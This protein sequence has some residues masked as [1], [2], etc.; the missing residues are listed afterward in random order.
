M[1]ADNRDVAGALPA[2]LIVRRARLED[3]EA[4]LDLCARGVEWNDYV[5][6]VFDEWVRD[7]G[8]DF[9]VAELGGRPVGIAHVAYDDGGQ[10]WFEGL[11]VDPLYRCRGIGRRL[12]RAEIECAR[13]RRCRVARAMIGDDNLPSRRVSEAEGMT[14]FLGMRFLSAPARPCPP[15]QARPWP[16]RA[17]PAG[18]GAVAAAVRTLRKMGVLRS[19]DG[20]PALFVGR[21]WREATPAAVEQCALA[22]QL[23]GLP[24]EGAGGAPG[25]DSPWRALFTVSVRHAQRLEVVAVA[26]PP[27]AT[28]DVAVAARDEAGRRGLAFGHAG[29][30]QGSPHEARL[31]EAGFAPP[32]TWSGRLGVWELKLQ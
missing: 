16:L 19:P 10:A 32:E 12:T 31:L 11:R 5:P 27:D 1:G 14:R 17:V 30:P 23:Y 29:A 24:P 25:A 3:R 18:D 7:P 20:A 13:R 26:G 2:D 4:V 9:I 8:S 28:Y 6:E 22:G 21:R 15:A